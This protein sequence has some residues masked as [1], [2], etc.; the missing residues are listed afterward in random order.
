MGLFRKT[1]SVST[2]GMVRWETDRQKRAD[3]AKRT[4]KAE[5]K[6]LEEQAKLV[7]AQRKALENNK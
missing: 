7:E 6:L 1:M 2:L 4:S 3:A 5:A